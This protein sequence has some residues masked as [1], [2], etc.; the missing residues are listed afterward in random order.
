MNRRGTREE[1]FYSLTAPRAGEFEEAVTAAF[2]WAVWLLCANFYLYGYFHRV[3][4]SVMVDELMRDFAVGAAVLGNLSAFYFYA[5]ASLQIPVGVLVDRYG[6]RRVL[7]AALLLCGAGSAIFATADVLAQ[8]YVGRFMIGAGAGFALVGTLKVAAVWLPAHRFAMVTGLT[9]M[10]G[11]VGAVGAQAPLAVVVEAMGWRGTLMAASGI[12]LVGMPLLLVAV[13]DNAEIEVRIGPPPRAGLVRSLR[14]IAAEPQTWLAAFYSLCMSSPVLGFAG[15]WGVPYMMTAHGLD[16]PA[17]A[18]STSLMLIGFG[19]GGPLFGGA[20]DALGRRK[21]PMLAGAIGMLATFSL[22]IY[23][24]GLPLWS[25]N[26]LL[27]ANG[28]FQGGMVI[29]FALARELNAPGSDG[30]TL[31]FLNTISMASGALFQPIIGWL[32]DLNWQGT[33]SEA[34]PIYPV[35]AYQTAFLVFLAAGGIAITAALCIR[36]THCRHALAREQR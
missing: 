6:P 16:R 1:F 21:L 19:L 32:L 29:S 28:V 5:Y 20:S 31:G 25:V 27:F 9:F 15:L 30:T 7:T 35:A 12:A 36:E 13:R 3:A 10:M 34:V 17:A 18:L 8:A 14:S 2:P 11:M 22:A 33:L 24:P 4:P 23:V 26:L